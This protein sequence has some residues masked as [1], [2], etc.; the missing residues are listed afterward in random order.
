MNRSRRTSSG[1]SLLADSLNAGH[2]AI[3]IYVGGA[4]HLTSTAAAATRTREIALPEK[5][6]IVTKLINNTS[7]ACAIAIDFDSFVPLTTAHALDSIKT[8]KRK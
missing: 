6:T 8:D 3:A 2:L 5:I 1:L 4:A 7:T